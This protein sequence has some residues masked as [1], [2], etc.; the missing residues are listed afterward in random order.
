MYYP[1]NFKAVQQLQ[2]GLWLDHSL[3]WNIIT[4]KNGKSVDSKSET[5]DHILVTIPHDLVTLGL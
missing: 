1:G 3:I 4:W 2:I 5:W